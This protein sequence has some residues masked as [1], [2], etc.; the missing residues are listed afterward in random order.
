MAYTTSV[1]RG[2]RRR[3]CRAPRRAAITRDDDACGAMKL[4]ERHAVEQ[5]RASGAPPSRGSPPTNQEVARSRARTPAPSAARA[6]RRPPS[7]ARGGAATRTMRRRDRTR[8]GDRGR[9]RRRARH[10]A[11]AASTACPSSSA[12]RRPRTGSRRVTHDTDDAE[13]P[14]RTTTH[15]ARCRAAV[16]PAAEQAEEDR[17]DGELERLRQRVAEAVVQGLPLAVRIVGGVDRRH[18]HGPG[19]QP[20][21]QR[22]PLPRCRSHVRP[23]DP[24]DA[25]PVA[26]L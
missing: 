14:N 9:G 11:G 7:T 13:A 5:A 1:T 16:E 15:R 8:R 21:C 6:R 26:R 23:I 24:A 18:G 19:G 4:E 25:R 10:T 2:R 17:G 12:M 20:L 3:R 22:T